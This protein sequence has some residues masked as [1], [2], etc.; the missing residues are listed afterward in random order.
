MERSP[1]SEISVAARAILGELRTHPRDNRSQIF[2]LQCAANTETIED[3]TVHVHLA[4]VRAGMS[5]KIRIALPEQRPRAA[6]RP[7][8]L[9]SETLMDRYTD[10][11]I[12]WVRLR[13]LLDRNEGE[14]RGQLIEGKHNVRAHSAE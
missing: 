13:I 12:S 4:K 2:L 10:G 6:G 3:L 7:D 1:G 14:E 5:A 11:P 8:A 9:I